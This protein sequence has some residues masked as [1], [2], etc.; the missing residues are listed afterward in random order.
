MPTFYVNT[1]CD[2]TRC[3]VQS[4]AIGMA[5]VALM[6]TFPASRAHGERSSPVFPVDF[7]L[8]GQ[9]LLAG[10]AIRIQDENAARF[11]RQYT[12]VAVGEIT[13]PLS[14]LGRITSG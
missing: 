4:D 3:A 2:H 12:P 11:S 7:D 1:S 14:K 5:V 10:W 8:R 9:P 13:R 6:A